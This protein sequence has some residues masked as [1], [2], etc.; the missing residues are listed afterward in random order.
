MRVNLTVFRYDKY[1]R[2]VYLAQEKH[3]TTDST[4]DWNAV[5]TQAQYELATLQAITK[6]KA[7]QLAALKATYNNAQQQV[8]NALNAVQAAQAIVIT[9]SYD[10]VITAGT[11][12]GVNSP[13]YLEAKRQYDAAMAAK[14]LAIDSA[15]KKLQEANAVRDA[16][17]GPYE[18]LEDELRDLYAAEAAA[19]QQII[20]AKQQLG[21]PA[22]PGTSAVSA[23]ATD[24]SAASATN[25]EAAQFLAGPQTPQTEAEQF[26]AGPQPAPG[27]N[28]AP[29]ATGSSVGLTNSTFIA[30]STATAQDN[31]NFS[32]FEDWRVRLSLAPGADYLYNALEPGI[33]APLAATGGVVFPYTPQINITYAAQYD[34]TKITHTNYSIYQYNSSSVDQVGIICDF[35]AQDTHEANYLLAV[36]HFFKSMTKMFYGQDNSPI[37]GTPPPLCFLFGLGGFQF[38]AHPLAITAFTYNLPNDVDY[39]RATTTTTSIAKLGET[40]QGNDRLPPGVLPGGTASPAS[41]S[42]VGGGSSPTYVPTKIQLSITCVPVMSRNTISNRFSLRDYATGKLLQGTKNPGGGIW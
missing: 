5:L 37:N 17:R 15:N 11:N 33:L 4:Q 20:Y 28:A 38:D 2:Q 41:F 29:N 14:K 26:L 30:Q 21:I 36:I 42:N 25:A 16:A 8:V 3:M 18:A 12:F 7:Q 27:A 31:A 40:V 34:S 24:P 39:I 22:P 10:A 35:T 9:P 13:Q 32:A 19:E 1:S 23:P 6:P